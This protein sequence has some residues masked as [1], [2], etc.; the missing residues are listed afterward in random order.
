METNWDEYYKKPSYLSKYTRRYTQSV[1]ESFIQSHNHK[2]GIKI[3]ELGGANSC[4]A[5]GILRNIKPEEY[6]VFDNNA[7]GLNLLINKGYGAKVV[8]HQCDLTKYNDSIKVDLVF[9]I[10]LI[11]HFDEEGTKAIIKTHFDMLNKNGIAIIS[12][13]T[14]TCLYRTAR[15]LIELCGAWHFHDERPL[16]LDEIRNDVNGIGHIEAVKMLYWLILTQQIVVIRKI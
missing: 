13:P 8:A 7:Y 6:H 12:Y 10:G 11:E 1:L 14:P 16:R 2:N 5:D 4:F 9:S 15:G 3:A